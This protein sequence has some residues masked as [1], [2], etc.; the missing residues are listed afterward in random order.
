MCTLWLNPDAA[1]S[2]LTP[3]RHYLEYG[4]P[5]DAQYRL[6]AWELDR[7]ANKYGTDK[8]SLY[9]NAHGYAAI[10]ES[11]LRH[12]RDEDLHILELGLLSHDVQAR[13]PLGPHVEAPSL[14]MWREYFPNARIVGF[15]IADFSN[16]PDIPGVRIIRGD[17]GDVDD[18]RRLIDESGGKFD[19]IIDDASHASH[20][21][22]VALS[23]LFPQ[24]NDEGYY[25]I[26]DLNFQPAHLELAGIVKTLDWLKRLSHNEAAPTP[27]ISQ[28]SLEY[29][30]AHVESIEFFDSQD[31]AFGTVPTDSIAAIKKTSAAQAA[32]RSRTTGAP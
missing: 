27:F 6:H 25:F 9:F 14:R 18:L 12:R 16:V 1:T 30:H 2:T 11:L 24:L 13:N 31:R 29:L 8:G 26:E 28:E 23:W 20:H 7:L 17:L 19:V 3:R 4:Q 10:Y 22:Q 21:Q 5:R 32:E 15:D